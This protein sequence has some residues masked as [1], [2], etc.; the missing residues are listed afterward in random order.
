MKPIK[1][2]QYPVPLSVADHKAL[3]RHKIIGLMFGKALAAARTRGGNKVLSLTLLELEEMTGW[4][5]GEANTAHSR[6]I[7]QELGAIGDH[8]ESVLVAIKQD[9]PE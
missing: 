2:I 1:P 6:R 4:V 7:S 3:V 5:V 8:L 9:Q